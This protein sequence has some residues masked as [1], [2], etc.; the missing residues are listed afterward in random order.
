MELEKRF[1]LMSLTFGVIGLFYSGLILGGLALIFGLISIFKDYKQDEVRAGIAL[2]IICVFGALV[3]IMGLDFAFNQALKLSTQMS[4]IFLT[5]PYGL[6]S[7]T[8]FINF[9][10]VTMMTAAHNTSLAAAIFLSGPTT[11]PWFYSLFF[12]ASI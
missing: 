9:I 2:G 7:S 4:L 3:E 12:S 11:I 10:T 1:A 5:F 8:F 6:G